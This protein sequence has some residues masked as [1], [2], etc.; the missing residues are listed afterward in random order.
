MCTFRIF[1]LNQLEEFGDIKFLV[2]KD[3]K[4]S[5]RYYGNMESF[6]IFFSTPS[7]HL[8]PIDNR[9]QLCPMVQTF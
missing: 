8:S 3:I 5:L 1:F 6:E 9:G 2:K 4:L 7:I